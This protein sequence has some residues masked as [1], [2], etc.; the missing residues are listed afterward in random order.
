VYRNL[1]LNRI[2]STLF[3]IFL[4]FALLPTAIFAQ[5]IHPLQ[6]GEGAHGVHSEPT[7]ITNLKDHR[8]DGSDEDWT[9]P[10]LTTSHLKPAQPMVGFV[11]EESGYTVSLVRLQWRR[12]DPIDLWIIKPTGVKNPPVILHLYGYPSE[13]EIFKDP[14]WQRLTT[15]GGFA[16]VGF[17]TALTGHRYHDV[18]LK[19]WFLSELQQCLG[20]ST[21][22]VQ[23]VMNYLASRGDLDMDRVGVMG[24]LSGASIGIL[25][26]AVDPRIKVLDT[27]DPWGDWP[28]WMEKSNFPPKQERANYVKQE[29]LSTVAPLDTLEWIPK[30]Q[31]KKFRLQQRHYEQQT[32]EIAKKKMEAAVPERATV[33]SYNNMNDFDKGVG[34]DGEKSL[35]W[36][37]D[38]L[39]ALPEG[40]PVS[41][42]ASKK[43]N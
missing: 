4:V 27:L 6:D 29:F 38:Q 7:Y 25:A 8:F 15:Q 13:T 16:S 43:S 22:D 39:R 10:A 2:A 40:A 5:E 35:D 30:V 32:P 37:K 41:A 11:N 21:H 12:G 19:K 18:P 36:I 17:V 1:L 14:D 28:V 9:S 24:Q 20:E 3:A 26:S 23:M 34:A 42:V 31:A 33:A